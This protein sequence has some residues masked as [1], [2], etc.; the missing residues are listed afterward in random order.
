ML[1]CVA[2]LFVVGSQLSIE[3]SMYQ[4]KRRVF[5]FSDS[6]LGC[7]QRKSLLNLGQFDIGSLER[8]HPRERE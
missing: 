7:T 6:T 4:Q 1:L 3:E 2:P 5:H 8:K